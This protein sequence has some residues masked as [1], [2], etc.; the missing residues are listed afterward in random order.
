MECLFDRF[1]YGCQFIHRCDAVDLSVE[2]ADSL[3]DTATDERICMVTFAMFVKSSHS[4]GTTPGAF[5]NCIDTVDVV[6]AGFG[7]TSQ[8]KG[9]LPF[10]IDFD[11]TAMQGEG[12]TTAFTDGVRLCEKRRCWANSCSR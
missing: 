7:I 12:I 1:V 5:C 6:F 10:G 2:G 8:H 4:P 3:V 11:F 9:V